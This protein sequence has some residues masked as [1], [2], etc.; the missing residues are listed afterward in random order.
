MSDE[1]TPGAVMSGFW[2][3]FGVGLFTFVILAGLIIG[4][5]QAGWWFSNQNTNR[6]AQQIQNGYSNQTSLHQQVTSN[7]ATVASIT[8]QVTETNN[9]NQIAALK[10]QRAA[11]AATAC[12]DASEVSAADPLPAGQQQWV[13][14][15]CSN[16]V[17][18]PSS[19]LYQAG[20]Q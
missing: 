5:W 16:G 2:R 11:I 15:N 20:T 6:Q 14:A 7:I 3:W 1:I 8:T 10:A 17:V 18:S 4:G 12:E 13:S 19:P 9:A